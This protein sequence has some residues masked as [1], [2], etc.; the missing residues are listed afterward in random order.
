LKTVKK[1]LREN[2]LVSRL[3]PFKESKLFILLLSSLLGMFAGYLSIIFRKAA[4]FGTYLFESSQK[5]GNFSFADLSIYIPIFVSIIF[6]AIYANTAFWGAR[7]FSSILKAVFKTHGHLSLNNSFKKLGLSLLSIIGKGSVGR[8]SMIAQCSGGFGSWLGRV[9]H[10]NSK[11]TVRLIVSSAA[12]AIA[13]TYGAPI[14]GILFAIE[15]LAEEVHVSLAPMIVAS[16]SASL[17][18]KSYGLDPVI[19]INTW[20]HVAGKDLYIFAILGI[21]SG[22]FGA[23]YSHASNIASKKLYEKKF[24]P[25]IA[26]FGI[27]ALLIYLP[28]LTGGGYEQAS[29][30][31]QSN[32]TINEML[33]YALGK[34]LITILCINSGWAGGHFGPI[35][36]IGIALGLIFGAKFSYISAS[37]AIAGAAA[38]CASI[39]HAPLAL[40]IL[41]WE[42]T[43]SSDVFI[44]VTICV[45]AAILVR[46]FFNVRNL[47]ESPLIDLLSKKTNKK[48]QKTIKE[49]MEKK[50]ET[51]NSDQKI[52]DVLYLT[53]T[54]KQTYFPVLKNERLNGIITRANVLHAL[55]ADLH[56]K[57]NKE[58]LN[59]KVGR[60]KS[61]IEEILIIKE[62]DLVIDTAHKMRVS[63]INISHLPV[64]NNLEEMKIVGV[65]HSEDVLK[66][67]DV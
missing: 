31:I 55:E 24:S 50:P 20:T 25:L 19:D 57:I 46:D 29:S 51:V 9:F 40:I 15:L 27:F 60:W 4:N 38:L 37:L 43:D 58:H 59:D 61:S 32:S 35:F 12:A 23:L 17:I 64:V 48:N 47:Y 26:G 67:L 5:I 22:M 41:T 3:R 54:K 62:N 10:L 36:S 56:G 45:V 6:V 16:L 21:L 14:A 7:G 39:T 63:G 28:D 11:K 65:L 30:M 44:P 52:K 8:E 42:M 18:V 13:A 34:A 49:I 66:A 2:V 1:S 53:R 33:V